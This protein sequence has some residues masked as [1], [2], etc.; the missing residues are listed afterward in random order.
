MSVE[1]SE[2]TTTR[3]PLSRVSKSYVRLSLGPGHREESS[4]HPCT[5][6]KGVGLGVGLTD[7]EIE[8]DVPIGPAVVVGEGEGESS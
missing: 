7:P 3:S 1:G 2:I 8:G 5:G 4:S 6:A